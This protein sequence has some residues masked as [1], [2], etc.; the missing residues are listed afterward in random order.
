[1]SQVLRVA[2]AGAVR[3]AWPRLLAGGAEAGA[4]DA[5][6]AGAGWAGLAG[7][8]A[9]APRWLRV[10]NPSPDHPLLV[11]ALVAPAVALPAPVLSV[12][13]SVPLI[14][15]EIEFYVVSDNERSSAVVILRKSNSHSKTLYLK[16]ADGKVAQK[17]CTPFTECV[18]PDNSCYRC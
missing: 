3:L 1:M 9:A 2:V 6:G 10:R 17:R 14:L 5:R 13:W 11:H 15:L 16:G 8:G 12:S 4:E 7:V 18:F